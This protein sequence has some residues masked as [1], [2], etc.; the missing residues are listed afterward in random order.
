M[1]MLAYARV[2]GLLG[3]KEE[4]REMLEELLEQDPPPDI[5]SDAR[6]YIGFFNE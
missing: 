5:V 4:A 2:T 6:F 1:A 3:N